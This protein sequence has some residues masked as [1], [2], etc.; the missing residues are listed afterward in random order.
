MKISACIVTYNSSKDIVNAA[1]SL[2]EAAKSLDFTLYISDNNSSDDTVTVAESHYKNNPRVVIIKNTANE[3]FGAG[4]NAPIKHL[5]SKYH[6]IVNP[7]ITVDG[8]NLIKIVDFL[9]ENPDVGMLCP[10]ILNEDGT[11]QI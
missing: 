2:L 10:K 8:D 9:E 4:H 1:D 6:F 3:G 5:E 7:D 11:E